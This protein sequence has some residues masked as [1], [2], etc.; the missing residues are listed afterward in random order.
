MPPAEHQALGQRLQFD[1]VLDVGATAE[2]LLH[3]GGAARRRVVAEAQRQL[4]AAQIRRQT[5]LNHRHVPASDR[6]GLPNES[7]SSSSYQKKALKTIDRI[8]VCTKN[9]KSVLTAHYSGSKSNSKVNVKSKC[10]RGFDFISDQHSS[11]Y[12]FLSK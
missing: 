3:F 2:A 8:I 7:S 9:I 10:A 11:D 1:L 12:G 4:L 6:N 5:Q